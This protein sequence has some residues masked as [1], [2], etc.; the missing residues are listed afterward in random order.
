MQPLP[1]KQ[2]LSWFLAALVV[3]RRYHLT[4]LGMVMFYVLIS[5]LLSSVPLVG[6]ILAGIW[7]P[8][9]TLLLVYATKQA[10]E[11]R[12]PTYDLFFSLF[13]KPKL[14]SSLMTLGLVY[15]AG[16]QFAIW[17]FFYFGKD[18]FKVLEAEDTAQIPDF[19]MPWDAFSVSMVIYL[20]VVTLTLFSPLLQA[21]AGQKL[22]KSIF[23]SFLGIVL[24]WRACLCAGACYLG[25][26]MLILV[27]F[28][29]SFTLLGLGS[30]F[31]YLAP[32]YVAV[33]TGVG[34]AMIWPMYSDIYGAKGGITHAE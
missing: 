10:L 24:Q 14:R 4:Y 27:F 7:M 17:I 21:D 12:L 34:Y 13:R 1:F 26:G 18:A 11:G 2:G 28:Y 6:G 16:L 15:A 22:G 25:L 19:Q 30:F 8:F 9:G 33:I 31:G 29:T 3:I 5:V 23:S 20:I 32:I